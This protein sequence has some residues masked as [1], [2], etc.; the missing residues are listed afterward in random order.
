MTEVVSLS[1]PSQ[2]PAA[3]RLTQRWAHRIGVTA[4]VG[5]VY[6]LVAEL[7]LGLYG[8]T[9]W[10][11]VFWPAFGVSSGILIALGPSA[12]WQVAIGVTAAILVAHVILGDPRWLG[13]A[14]GLADAVEALVT[15][16]VIECFF[17]AHFSL[18]RLR[19]VLGLFGAAIPGSIASFTT[20]MLP[21]K[22]FQN[23]TEPILTTWQHWFMGDMV[24]FVAL[25]PFVIGFFAAV[26]HPPGWRELIEG[27][28]GL[29]ALALITAIIILLPKSYWDTLVPVAWLFPM[30]FWLAARCRP[31]F[32]AAGAFIVSITVVWTTV[33][34]IGHFGN[35]GLAVSDRNL[36]AQATILAVALGALVLSALFAERRD[37]EGRLARSNEMLQ[38]ERDTKLVSAQAITASIAHELK[39]PLTAVAMN[40]SAAIKFLETTPPNYAEVRAALR[41]IIDDASRACETMDGIRALFRWIK[42]RQESVDVNEVIGDALHDLSEELGDYRVTVRIELTQEIPLVRGNKHQLREVIVNLV[43]NAIEAMD[44][45]KDRDRILWVRSEIRDREAIAVSVQ[46]TGPGI[47]PSRLDSIFDAFF[48]TKEKGMGLG[49]AICRLIAEHHSGRLTASSNGKDGAVFQFLLPVAPL[50]GP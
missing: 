28:A 29:V 17:G 40:G 30:L 37:N 5:V 48:T 16:G 10:V 22:I 39:Q 21:A 23:S 4:A 6:F 35:S 9:N 50:P 38:R 19:H 33:F 43:H 15:A 27:A 45:T 7:G 42:G 13:P 1:S 14:F 31:V 49:L 3:G 2:Q 47:D 24:G 46:D 36:Q 8:Q 20:W 12:R 32:A 44:A 41:D 34:G 18:G 26:R 25:G 11:S